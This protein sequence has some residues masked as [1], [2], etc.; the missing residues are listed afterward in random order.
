MAW[1]L[2]AR[3]HESHAEFAETSAPQNSSR[4][5]RRERRG[6]CA[7]KSHAEFA[8]YAEAFA[9]KIHHPY[10][11]GMC[12]VWKEELGTAPGVLAG[13][14]AGPRVPQPLPL[15]VARAQ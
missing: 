9:P 1:A 2:T 8:K 14:C 6:C 15:S 7:Q 12:G 11:L 13:V 3:P 4:R 10:A 5:E